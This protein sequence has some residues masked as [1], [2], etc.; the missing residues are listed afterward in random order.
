MGFCLSLIFAN[1]SHS[2]KFKAELRRN[3]GGGA[4]IYKAV[5]GK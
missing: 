2:N 4:G 5:E 3:G 1:F